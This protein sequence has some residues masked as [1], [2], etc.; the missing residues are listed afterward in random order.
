MLLGIFSK[1]SPVESLLN[2]FSEVGFDLAD[3]SVI[4]KDVKTRDA[5]ADDDGPLKG[6]TLETLSARLLQA[7]VPAS[8]VE[9]C[10]DA[11]AQGKV[12]VAMIPPPDA[13]DAAREMF[14]DV[15]AELIEEK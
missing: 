5:V 3:V 7:G 8:A 15:S 11:V 2:N 14:Q 4:M 13:Q 12:L 10:R 9:R 1:T 6:A